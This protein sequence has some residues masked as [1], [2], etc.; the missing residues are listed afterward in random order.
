M[1][2][3]ASFPIDIFRIKLPS[4]ALQQIG[5][6]P[7]FFLHDKILPPVQDDSDT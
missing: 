6:V 4:C 7:P 3:A 2:D 1:A 5:I